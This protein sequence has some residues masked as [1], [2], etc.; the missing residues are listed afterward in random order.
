VHPYESS[1]ELAA[2]LNE[3]DV[4]LHNVLLFVKSWN[5]IDMIALVLQANFGMVPSRA[6][7]CHLFGVFEFTLL[8]R[9]PYAVSF[10]GTR[11]KTT[12][13]KILVS[14]QE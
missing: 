14:L 7:W 6:F 11:L 9:I 10:L 1:G 13:E 2:A 3:F 8:H 5:T 12:T 4:R